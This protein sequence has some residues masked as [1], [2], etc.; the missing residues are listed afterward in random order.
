MD[1]PFKFPTQKAPA[2]QQENI[3]H[4]SEKHQEA[5]LDHALTESFP[6]SDPVAISTTKTTANQD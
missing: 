5:A 4:K 2:P 3:R 6:A 1:K